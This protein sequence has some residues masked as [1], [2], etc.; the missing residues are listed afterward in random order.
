M[1]PIFDRDCI[2]V[3]W[4]EPC[5]KNVFD[6]EM[7]W[8]AFVDNEYLYSTSFKWL[9]AM[10]DGIFVDK[11]GD[12]VCWLEG[13]SL[14]GVYNLTPPVTFPATHFRPLTPLREFTPLRPLT[15]LT[16]LREFT[17]LRDWSPLN[18]DGYIN[19]K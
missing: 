16:P 11:S 1:K 8:V 19:P 13:G 2:Q 17:S 9:G 5:D 6:K 3:G 15:P 14:K 12:P 10:I 4:Y 7:H 18:W